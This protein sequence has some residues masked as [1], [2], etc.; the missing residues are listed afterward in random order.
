[1][2]IILYTVETCKFSAEEREYLKS[3]NLP[4][5]EKDVEKDHASLEEML[6]IGNNFAGTP[7]THIIFDE[8]KADA[9]PEDKKPEENKDEKKEEIDP[10]KAG[11]QQKSKTVVLK[12]FTKEEFDAALF[13][14]EVKKNPPAGGETAVAADPNAPKDPNAPLDLNAPPVAAAPVDPSAPPV[15]PVDPN[16]PPVDPNAPA[17][18]APPTTA[19]TPNSL[20]SI[21]QDLQSKIPPVDPNAPAPGT[22]PQM[23]PAQPTPGTPPGAPQAPAG[24]PPTPAVP[25]FPGQQ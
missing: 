18:A 21:L 24:A 20:D 22:S 6:K 11:D 23:P 16:A 8:V 14:E 19:P 25:D 17:P 4:F 2:K 13:P 5:E 15:A 7:V 3:K 9:K 10:Y 12:G 1:M